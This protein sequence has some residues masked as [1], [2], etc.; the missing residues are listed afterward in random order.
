[1]GIF[2]AN[3]WSFN[4]FAS[5]GNHASWHQTQ[6]YLCRQR[7]RTSIRRFGLSKIFWKIELYKDR[8]TFL[9]GSWNHQIWVIH[10]KSGYLEFGRH[11]IPTCC[12][13]T[14]LPSSQFLKIG[15]KHHLLRTP[16]SISL[17]E[18]TQGL[19]CLNASQRSQRKTFSSRLIR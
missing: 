11:D 16:I 6:Q 10:R 8:Y 4:L 12:F 9:F 14:A 7:R 13:K 18:K 5:T 1:M 17:F 19:Y 2:K 15:P 3:S